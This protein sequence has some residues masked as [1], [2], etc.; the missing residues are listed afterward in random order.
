MKKYLFL[1][2]LLVGGSLGLSKMGFGG[3]VF[4]GR[5]S[6][7]GALGDEESS[8]AWY[9]NYEFWAG[10][11]S[12]EGY[13]PISESGSYSVVLHKQDAYSDDS[14]LV[15]TP[16][17]GDP[18]VREPYLIELSVHSDGSMSMDSVSSSGSMTFQPN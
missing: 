15:M 10:T 9:Q 11:Y 18:Y 12:M 2:V 1:L 16:T 7:S 5:W 3:R 13:P 6:A 14:I 17:E 4:E 8:F